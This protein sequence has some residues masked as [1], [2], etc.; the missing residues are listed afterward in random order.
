LQGDLHTWKQAQIIFVL[1]FSLGE[2]SKVLPDHNAWRSRRDPISETETPL[3]IVLRALVSTLSV[4]W[5]LN[6]KEASLAEIE[7][8]HVVARNAAVNA[9]FLYRLKQYV[10]NRPSKP[11]RGK[12]TMK[13]LSLK[14][15]TLAHFYF[16]GIKFYY[17]TQLPYYQRMYGLHGSGKDTELTERFHKRVVKQPLESISNAF[18]GRLVECARHMQKH[19]HAECMRFKSNLSG[20]VVDPLLDMGN[21]V[22]G[23]DEECLLLKSSK[24]Q[25]FSK[26]LV[27][28][29]NE[30]FHSGNEAF[31]GFPWLHPNVTLHILFEVMSSHLTSL[32]QRLSTRKEYLLLKQAMGNKG[33]QHQGK[34]FL[35][36][37]YKMDCGLRCG[38]LGLTKGMYTIRAN[39]AYKDDRRGPVAQR[40]T[41]AVN[42]FVFAMIDEDI[43][44]V[45]ILG[46]LLCQDVDHQ[47]EDVYCCV[48]VMCPAEQEYLPFH[49]YK[50]K[51]LEGSDKPD[52]RVIDTTSI[53]SPCFCVPVQPDNYRVV[54]DLQATHAR[55]YN[56]PPTRI[57]PRQ[58][59]YEVYRDLC[60]SQCI[61]SFRTVANMNEV[62]DLLRKDVADFKVSAEGQKLQKAE[63]AKE[64]RKEQLAERKAATRTVLPGSDGSDCRSDHSDTC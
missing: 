9:N 6:K 23:D 52:L 43:E 21:G 15:Y 62:N 7:V 5:F 37:G 38:D 22:D 11:V 57:D 31:N 33:N 60:N 63:A 26:Q 49:V 42:S 46:I 55:F 20:E 41:H 59:S 61:D 24:T 4:V 29:S 34:L 48:V 3:R 28:V 53:T 44:L 30:S 51:H 27:S 18:G 8:F 40:Q 14:N 64:K 50:Y 16:T 39:Q 36:E 19:A 56:I 32:Q 17:M 35:C 45:R 54:D 47:G 58:E 1:I 10:V 2:D 13:H 12:K 25:S